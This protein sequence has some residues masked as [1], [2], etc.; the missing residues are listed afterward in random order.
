MPTQPDDHP[1]TALWPSLAKYARSLCVIATVLH[2]AACSSPP[3]QNN[4]PRE[5]VTLRDIHDPATPRHL[6]TVLDVQPDR[7]KTAV[8]ARYH[9]P[10][11]RS[12]D[13]IWSQTN[14]S[15]IP[16]VPRAMW[17]ANGLR[18]SII[19]E[20]ELNDFIDALPTPLGSFQTALSATE[21]PTPIRTSPRLRKPVVIDLTTPP[22]AINETRAK[23]GRL[24]LLAK[25][26]HDGDSNSLQLTPHHYKTKS[27]LRRQVDAVRAGQPG[28]PSPLQSALEGDIYKQLAVNI[29][30][31]EDKLLIIGLYWPWESQIKKAKDLAA[32]KAYERKMRHAE[33]RHKQQAAGKSSTKVSSAQDINPNDID[34]GPI[35]S[36]ADLPPDVTPPNLQNNLGRALFT[37][38]YTKVPIQ[39]ILIVGLRDANPSVNTQ[40]Q[41]SASEAGK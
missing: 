24:Q 14:Q 25:L 28:M 33:Q 32:L 29:D 10:L 30:L 26:V 7:L 22:Y 41:S 6:P 39:T 23:G 8:I 36:Q 19:S 27:I 4:L 12:L 17:A 21:Y 38:N 16:S 2:L 9:L 40:Y 15:A 13:H 31:P 37:G 1:K 11:Y 5:D 35:T 3:K 20:H 34:P 18:V